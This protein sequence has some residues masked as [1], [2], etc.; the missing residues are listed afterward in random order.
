MALQAL[1]NLTAGGDRRS[2]MS[3]HSEGTQSQAQYIGEC[4]SL[5]P[6]EG[7]FRKGCILVEWASHPGGAETNE[8]NLTVDKHCV[9]F[10]QGEQNRTSLREGVGASG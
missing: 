5:S 7:Q 4:F 6:A 1:S 8:R 2:F 3:C 10:D 9:P